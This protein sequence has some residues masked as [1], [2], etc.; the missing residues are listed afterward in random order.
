MAVLAVVFLHTAVLCS[1]FRVLLHVVHRGIR[2]DACRRHRVP[3]VLSQRHVTAAHFPG[4][5]VASCKHE[6]FGAITFC[7]TTGHLPYVSLFLRKPKR[8]SRENHTQN[9]IDFHSS[10]LRVRVL[11]C[12]RMAKNI[13]ADVSRKEGVC[14]LSPVVAQ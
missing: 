3:Y 7:Q 6:F 9:Q 2:D 11:A 14:R 10:P 5:S 4:T 13:E 12:T 1:L 8:A